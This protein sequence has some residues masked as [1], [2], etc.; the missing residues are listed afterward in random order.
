PGIRN[1]VLALSQIT[2]AW[3]A[4]AENKE[5]SSYIVR[6]FIATSN[7]V[8]QVYPATLID[9]SYDATRRDWYIRA[10]E[11][12]GKMILTA[13]YLD[14]GG[15]GYVITLSHTIFEGKPTAMHSPDDNIVAV[16]GIDFTFGYFYKFLLEKIPACKL[17]HMIC[18]LLDDKGYLVSHPDLIDPT[19]RGPLEQQH[20]THK[21]PDDIENKLFLFCRSLLA[22]N[23][24]LNH[25]AFVTK[26]LCAS[27]SDPTI[28]RYYELNTSLDTVLTN[29]VHGEHCTKYQVMHVYGT[30][31]F[32]GIVNQTCDGIT[33]FCPCSMTDRLCLNCH[34]MEPTE[35]ECPCECPLKMDLCSGQLNSDYTHYPICPHFPELP[36]LP[37]VNL[38]LLE[39][40]EPCY[41]LHCSLRTE[42]SDCIEYWVVSGSRTPY[43]DE[44]VENLP[45]N[46]SLVVTSH[47]IGAVSG[48][49]ISGF[50][51]V[52]FVMFLV[53]RKR[54][55]SHY[56]SA[57]PDSTFRM[58]QLNNEP[59]EMEP[60]QEPIHPVTPFCRPPIPHMENVASPY[61]VPTHY[62]RPAGGDS[63]H[64]YSTMTP[65]EDSELAPYFEPLLLGRVSTVPSQH[66]T[67]SGS[68]TSSPVSCVPS[69]TCSVSP[70]ILKMESGVPSW[71]TQ[72]D[73]LC[74]TDAKTRGSYVVAHVQV[75]SENVD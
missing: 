64:G 31:L 66:S 68:R 52:A 49:I 55:P 16:M 57:S 73:F 61:R 13:P 37:A 47:S 63:D 29:L 60:Y 65:H 62:R 12:P 75:H 19:G 15:A 27:Y 43:A 25:R 5:F 36:N 74:S 30:N 35:C 32:L 28:Q 50:L 10:L 48:G 40:L 71:V 46:G 67:S 72:R 4:A 17:D 26:K 22:A 14:V 59:E 6:R 21:D 11:H 23:D 56:R 45:E 3:K 51:F 58:T 1:E 53:C 39:H 24:L 18:F 2:S 69:T 34:R 54:R 7:G 70:S 9:K 20:I 38:D 8:F 44:I 42:A 41:E 33:A